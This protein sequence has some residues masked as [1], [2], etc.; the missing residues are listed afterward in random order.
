[1]TFWQALAIAAVPSAAAVSSAALGFRDLGMRRRLE[2][3][4][5]F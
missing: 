3:S 1:M 5:Q 2:T 4:K